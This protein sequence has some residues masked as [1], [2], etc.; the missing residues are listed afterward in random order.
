MINSGFKLTA[1]DTQ[2]LD[3][4]K[5]SAAYSTYLK[6]IKN[7]PAFVRVMREH[8]NGV[9]IT[10]DV[11]RLQRDG[12]LPDS[13]SPDALNTLFK[14]SLSRMA[15][16]I[17]ADSVLLKELEDKNVDEV[18]R[19]LKG[20]TDIIYLMGMA[21]DKY[22]KEAEKLHEEG[23]L[24]KHDIAF[25]G[26]IAWLKRKDVVP[27]PPAEV[28]IPEPEPTPRPVTPRKSSESKKQIDYDSLDIEL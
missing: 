2:K 26:L 17:V 20:D 25:R 7:S 10:Q 12:K 11:E 22:Y 6:S 1:K 24:N 13:V 14:Q 4:F 18:M 27:T 21:D 23:K 9:D 16:N 8:I 15:M 28:E 19:E 5:E 3:E